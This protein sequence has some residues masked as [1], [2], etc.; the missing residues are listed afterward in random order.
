MLSGFL[1]KLIV[2]TKITFNNK[3]CNYN[4][5]GNDDKDN[6][7]NSNR[8]GQLIIINEIDILLDEQKGSRGTKGQ[9]LMDET[10]LKDCKRRKINVAMAWIDYKKIY[11][12]IY[13]E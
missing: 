1:R 8:A 9:L 5:D 4:N 2:K 11:I 13:S 12:Y 7:K 3:N 10:L 6:N